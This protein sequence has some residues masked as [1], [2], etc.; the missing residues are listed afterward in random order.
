MRFPRHPCRVRKVYR[1]NSTREFARSAR[2][3]AF[4]RRRGNTQWL[5]KSAKKIA[6]RFRRSPKVAKGRHWRPSTNAWKSWDFVQ[7]RQGRQLTHTPGGDRVTPCRHFGCL[8]TRA[9]V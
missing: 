6:I 3:Y 4:A 1:Q 7:V 8:D 5:G 9:R 2:M